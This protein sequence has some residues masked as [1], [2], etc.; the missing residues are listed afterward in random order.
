MSPLENIFLP[1]SHFAKQS[2]ILCD[3]DIIIFSALF[4]HAHPYFD[5]F[6][7]EENKHLQNDN[8]RVEQIK[9]LLHA[10]KNERIKLD[11]VESAYKCS[12][13]INGFLSPF[14]V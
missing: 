6:H 10:R 11:W 8:N 5:T 13:W 12:L 4:I 1:L 7:A 3:F 2:N 9:I 14:Y